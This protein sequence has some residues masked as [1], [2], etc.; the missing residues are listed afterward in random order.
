MVYLNP[1]WQLITE[2]YSAT[3]CIATRNI[4]MKMI[5]LYNIF[6]ICASYGEHRT[7]TM[8]P[9]TAKVIK[10]VDGDTY[11]VLTNDKRSIRIRMNGIDAPEKKQPF[12]QKS[13]E[14]LASLCAGQELKIIP[15]GYDRNK[16]MLADAI[17]K[18]GQNI[19]LEMVKS[20]YAWHYKKYSKDSA[21]ALAEINARADRIG[22]WAD[23]NPIEP[24][25]WR[26]K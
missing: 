12:G 19:N 14:K 25:N 23:P 3:F 13:K 24:W 1:N 17:N 10:I 6:L 8:Q 20:G 11:D 7:D 2:L 18:L 16:R 15:H 4:P 22:L 26:K 9:F 21:L 5:L